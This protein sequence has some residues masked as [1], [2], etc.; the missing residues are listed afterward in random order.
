MANLKDTN[1]CVN[2]EEVYPSRSELPRRTCV[3]AC[4]VCGSCEHIRLSSLIAPLSA[5]FDHLDREGLRDA[6]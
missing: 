2:C 5:V 3:V 1:L 4:P 6:N